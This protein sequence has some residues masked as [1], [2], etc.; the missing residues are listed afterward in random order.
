MFFATKLPF[1]VFRKLSN[2]PVCETN[3]WAI[4]LPIMR[5]RIQRYACELTR[6]PLQNWVK[7]FS[8]LSS[9][10]ERTWKLIHEIRNFMPITYEI[11]LDSAWVPINLICVISNVMHGQIVSLFITCKINQAA[12]KN[13]QNFIYFPSAKL[14]KQT[15]QL[16][17]ILWNSLKKPE[18]H[19]SSR[20][21]LGTEN[22][23]RIIQNHSKSV[24]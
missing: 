8:L 6:V 13:M 23:I 18:R 7:T 17:L 21:N 9:Y 3:W 4:T 2:A 1:A 22:F 14:W 24:R 19:Q 11:A 12:S 10:V 15:A 5:L 20:Q 16:R